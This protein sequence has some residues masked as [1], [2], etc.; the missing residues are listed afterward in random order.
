MGGYA[1]KARGIARLAGEVVAET[2]WPT[3][4]ALCDAPGQVLCD[5]CA[6]KL[7]FLDWWRACPRCGSAFGRV[8]C[9]LCNPVALGRIGR[10]R[11]PFSGCASAVVFSEPTGRLV[12]VYKDH[13]ERRLAAVIAGYMARAVPPGWDFDTLTYIPATK[14]AFRHRG[15]DHCELLAGNVAQRLGRPQIRTLERPHAR[16]QRALSARERIE[17]LRSGL[18]PLEGAA[19][20]RRLLLVDDVLTTGSTL[21]AATDALMDAGAQKVFCLTF[22]RV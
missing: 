20:G 21:C 7:P 3:R 6:R 19:C 14:A 17:N 16:D 18:V 15:F 1:D 22:A 9:D 10:E 2:L 13:G 5:A 12:R 8:Q 4:C 11:L